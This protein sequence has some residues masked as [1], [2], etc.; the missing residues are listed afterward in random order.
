MIFKG[1]RE[2]D[3]EAN[4]KEMKLLILHTSFETEV[5]TMALESWDNAI[6]GL[7]SKRYQIW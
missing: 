4:L 1:L 7:Q 3:F 5:E 6:T 2:E